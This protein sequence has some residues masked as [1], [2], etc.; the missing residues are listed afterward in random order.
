[1]TKPCPKLWA[2]IPL[3]Y[4]SPFRTKLGYFLL[5]VKHFAELVERMPYFR[6][7]FLTYGLCH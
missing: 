7:E 4:L 5:K 1:M 6:E 3:I 2:D